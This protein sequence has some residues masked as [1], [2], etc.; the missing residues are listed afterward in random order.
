VSA[1]LGNDLVCMKRTSQKQ[2]GSWNT[3][4]PTMEQIQWTIFTEYHGQQR[5]ICAQTI[6]NGT[7]STW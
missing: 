4:S 2:I 3:K 5:I 6:L 1:F 7:F